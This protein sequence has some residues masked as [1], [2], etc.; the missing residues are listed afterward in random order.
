MAPVDVSKHLHFIILL[1]VG[2]PRYYISI[3][4]QAY[5]L[6]GQFSIS[7]VRTSFYS[8]RQYIFCLILQISYFLP[9]FRN[10]SHFRL[11]P[12]A[13][14]YYVWFLFYMLDWCSSYSTSI[15]LFHVLGEIVHL[16]PCA[17]HLNLN[18]WLLFFSCIWVVLYIRQSGRFWLYAFGQCLFHMFWKFIFCMRITCV[19]FYV[20]VFVLLGMSGQL[21]QK[22]IFI[23]YV[24][25]VVYSM[26]PLS[27]FV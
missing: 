8:L 10:F 25:I 6:L 12:L 16:I 1:C 17:T 14:V 13:F 9:C 2:I 22:G 20:F 3:I 23:E 5:Y 7:C 11:R 15:F 24:R 19:L 18:V 27:Y 4:W 21:M 26:R